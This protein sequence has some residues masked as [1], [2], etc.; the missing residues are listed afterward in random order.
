MYI[1]DTITRSQYSEW[2]EGPLSST[3]CSPM[4]MQFTGCQ[5]PV[6]HSYW[7]ENAIDWLR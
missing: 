5:Q 4:F 2:T 6:Q 3:T 7:P 1:N